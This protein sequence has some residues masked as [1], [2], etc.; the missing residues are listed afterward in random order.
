MAKGN[1]G[2]RAVI[3]LASDAHLVGHRFGQ[4]A[5]LS[6]AGTK[7]Y[8]SGARQAL[9]ECVCD[10]GGH[11]V[12]SGNML[13]GGKVHSC[14]CLYRKNRASLVQTRWRNHASRADTKEMK[15][16]A[17]YRCNARYH[18]RDFELTYKQA[19]ELFHGNCYYCGEPPVERLNGIDR[20]INL[21]GY[22]PLNCVSCCWTCN[23]RKGANDAHVFLEWIEKVYENQ[24][25]RDEYEGETFYDRYLTRVGNSG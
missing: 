24:R 19:Y 1:I 4:L 23:S 20:L 12:V 18:K 25:S 3:S 7:S 17:K 2:K 22:L 14:G 8:P 16:Y 13:Q 5:V 10:C 15:T 21:L 11:K 9:Y 6:Y